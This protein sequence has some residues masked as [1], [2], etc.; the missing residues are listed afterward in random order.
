MLFTNLDLY[1]FGAEKLSKFTIICARNEIVGRPGRG[2]CCAPLEKV[3]SHY[4]LS[5]LS[6]IDGYRVKCVTNNWSRS[7]LLYILLNN[8]VFIGGH[9][10]DGDHYITRNWGMGG[11]GRIN[12]FSPINPSTGATCQH[13][14]HYTIAHLQ[15]RT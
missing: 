6:L 3:V 11:G 13:S 15:A 14:P 7:I 4:T 9:Q 1:Q 12:Q 5:I 2:H 8:R 10:F